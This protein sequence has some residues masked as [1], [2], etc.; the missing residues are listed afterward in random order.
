MK[1]TGVH[2]REILD[3]RGYPTVEA[4]VVLDCGVM[5]RAAVPS[6]ASTGT[7]EAHELRDNDPS[8]YLGKGVQKAVAHVNNIIATA[9]IGKDAILQEDIDRLMMDLDG[10]PNKSKLGANAILAVSLAVAHAAAA[11]KG[12]P[13]FQHLNPQANRLPMPMFNILNGGAHAGYNVDIQ[14]FMVVPVGAHSFAQALRMGAEVYHALKK[15]LQGMHFP[16]T[17][18]DEGGFA[19]HVGSHRKALQIICDAIEAAGYKAG[20]DVALALDV[21]ASEFYQD[22]LYHL[23]SEGKTLR[24]DQMIDYLVNLTNQYPIISVEDGLSEEDWQGWQALTKSVGHR[25]Q[26]VGD[27]LF[28][29]NS[30]RLQMGIE[31]KC[32]NAVLIKLNQIGTLTETLDCM[33]MAKDKNYHCVVSHRSGETEDTTIAHLS[34]ATNAGRIK[35]GSLSRTERLCKYNELLRIEE[36]LGSKACFGL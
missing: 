32:G 28:V 9:L 22:G 3:S 15:I 11:G 8:R 31:K 26:L 35:A 18:G 14:E 13:L 10:T 21:A 24:T 5:G 7:F 36:K 29:T 34:V 12:L 1:I 20:K 17:V 4:E 33:Q 27:D 23:N 19:P 6:G 25:I 2:A 30:A 16:T